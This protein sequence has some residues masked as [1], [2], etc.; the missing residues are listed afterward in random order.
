MLGTSGVFLLGGLMVMGL[1]YLVT[2]MEKYLH[3]ASVKALSGHSG[4]QQP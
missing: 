2:R 3:G 4:E 1:A